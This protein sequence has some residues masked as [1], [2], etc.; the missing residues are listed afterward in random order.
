[1][2]VGLIVALLFSCLIGIFFVVV[3]YESTYNNGS[4]KSISKIPVPRFSGPLRYHLIGDFGELRKNKEFSLDYPPVHAVA[5]S[6]SNRAKSAPISMITTAGDNVY[7]HGTGLF[8][9]TLYMLLENVFK[10]EGLSDIPWFPV[11]GNHDC[12]IPKTKEIQ[13]N[14]LY[15]Q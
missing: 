13:M 9:Q 4:T 8:D 11:L 12:Y 7:T 2:K 5:N 3:L 1:M 14:A 6:M 15:P 10:L